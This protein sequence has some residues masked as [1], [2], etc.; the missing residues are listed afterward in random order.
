MG[1]FPKFMIVFALTG[2][3]VSLSVGL[4]AGNRLTHVLVTS[5]ICTAIGGALGAGVYKTLEMRVPEAL[6]LLQGGALSEGNIDGEFVPVSEDDLAG[7]SGYGDDSDEMAEVNAQGGEATAR[8]GGNQ[9][10]GDHIIV[11]DVKIKNEP[12]LMAKAIQTMLSR[13][14]DS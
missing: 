9:E 6:A 7:E 13:D 4:I 11:N 8:S 3:I 10:F 2:L 14:E 5:F 12:K 1:L